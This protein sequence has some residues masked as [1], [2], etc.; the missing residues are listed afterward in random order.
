M[1]TR[2][3]TLDERRLIELIADQLSVS[4]GATLR[5]DARE[6]RAKVMDT[7]GSLV[8]FEIA[9]YN[10]PKYHGQH[11]FGVEGVVNDEDGAQLSVVLYADENGRLLELEL[12]RPD[13]GPIRGP[14]WNSLKLF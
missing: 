11:S 4:E 9:G 2:P 8:R 3:L 6:A 7:D 14:Q 5:A 10:R 1:N 12:I 13:L